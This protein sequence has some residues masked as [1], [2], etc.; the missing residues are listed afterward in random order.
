METKR[1]LLR[2]FKNE[3]VVDVYEYLS[4]LKVHCFL[5][6][7]VKDINEVSMDERIKYPENYF[8]VVLKEENKVIG[9]IFAFSQ[10]GGLEYQNA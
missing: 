8:D 4:Q 7:K 5:D 2:P 10:E 6:M 3:D 9:E 1:I